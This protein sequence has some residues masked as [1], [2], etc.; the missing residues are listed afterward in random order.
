MQDCTH[1]ILQSGN[2]FLFC[3]HDPVRWVDPTGRVIELMGSPEERDILLSYL[4]MLTDHQLDFN[5]DNGHVFIVTNAC[6]SSTFIYGNKLIERIILSRHTTRI[7][8]TSGYNGM[9]RHSSGSPAFSPERG[10]GSR[11]YFNPNRV[12]YTWVTNASGAASLQSV[13][14]NIVLAH[15]LIHADRAMRG[16]MFEY[17]RTASVSFTM[18]RAS[19][20]PMRLLSATTTATH[21]IPLEDAATISL[22]LYTDTCIT[23]NMI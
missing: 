2:L 15:E 7:R 4:Q 9:G 22:R 11:I 3:G 21:R 18:Y 17:H 6:S 13:P 5:R 16:V 10:A 19:F 23:E 12:E 20:N 14:A 8:L 1:S